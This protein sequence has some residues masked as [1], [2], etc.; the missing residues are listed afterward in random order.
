MEELPQD[1]LS[2]IFSFMLIEH[3][4]SVARVSPVLCD[5]VWKTVPWTNTY[6]SAE[7]PGTYP[8]PRST[9][10]LVFKPR[11]PCTWTFPRLQYLRC[12]TLYNVFP[13]E[14]INAGDFPVL[15]SCTLV[16]ERMDNLFVRMTGTF[17]HLKSLSCNNIGPE[18]MPTPDQFPALE[19][20]VQLFTGFNMPS[21]AQYITEDVVGKSYENLKVL[22]FYPGDIVQEVLVP[23][24]FP[25]IR[26]IQ[27]S[28]TDVEDM[29][30]LVYA[31]VG[32]HNAANVSYV[33]NG[34]YASNVVTIE[35]METASDDITVV[36]YDKSVWCSEVWV[37]MT[38]L[39]SDH[40]A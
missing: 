16:S 13:R 1:C 21:H 3:I 22:R 26:R 40:E 9:K 12:L 27:T 36:I 37:T 5:M 2:V 19:N 35:L 33:C 32:E 17:S 31:F 20:Y 7:L 8:I 18:S 39:L 25:A 24:I 14:G 30:D 10:A 29:L 11:N 28:V 34:L 15:Q 23:E 4:M 6:A 38:T